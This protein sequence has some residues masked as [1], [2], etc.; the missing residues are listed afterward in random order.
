MGIRM[1]KA[2]GYGL[3]IT[4]MNLDA[5]NWEK[6]EDRSLFEQFIEEVRSYAKEHDDLRERMVFHP[7]QM[8]QMQRRLPTNFYE[9]VKYDSEFGF[10]EKLLLIPFGYTESWHRYGDLLDTFEYEACNDFDGP[11]WMA[12]EWIEKKGTLYP[13]VGLMKANPEKPFGIEEYWISCYLSDERHKDATPVA[14]MHLWFVIKLLGLAPEDQVTETFLKL[15]PTIYR[16]W[17]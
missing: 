3:D 4:G 6:L 7:N 1:H 9:M 17:S 10:A 14:P 13:F 15:R 8:D 11:N 5:L 2:V 12:P 16:W